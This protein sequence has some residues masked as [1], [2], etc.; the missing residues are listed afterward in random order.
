MPGNDDPP[1]PGPIDVAPAVRAF[2]RHYVQREYADAR[3]IFNLNTL[4]LWYNIPIETLALMLDDIV[5]ADPLTQDEALGFQVFLSSAKEQRFFEP[6]SLR[7]MND[8]SSPSALMMRFGYLLDLRLRGHVT[9][10]LSLFDVLRGELA[11]IQPFT[12]RRNSWPQFL[13]LQQGITAMLAGDFQ[14]ALNHF[15]ETLARS[16]TPG[17]EV[18]HRNAII[19]SALLEA[20]FG[21]PQAAQLLYDR[22]RKVKRTPS[23]SEASIDASADLVQVLLEPDPQL[24]GRKLAMLDLA[25]VGEMWPFYVF[26]DYIVHDRAGAHARISTRLENMNALPF[27]R[28]SGE[29][30]SGSVLPLAMASH[31]LY[32]GASQEARDLVQQAD[33]NHLLT[34][35]VVAMVELRAGSPQ[36]TIR[37]TKEVREETVE[38]RRAELWRISLCAQAYLVLGDRPAMINV[39]REIENLFQPLRPREVN[40]FTNELAEA[41]RQSFDW[42][43][44]GELDHGAYFERL[45]LREESLTDREQEVLELLALGKTRPQI[46]ESLY[47]SLN[48]LKTQL[49]SVYRK[50]GAV[51]RADA[52]QK[53]SHRGLL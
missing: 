42:W 45:P 15:T 11:I 53:A 14:R 24:A 52:L 10:A 9:E 51:S 7:T 31:K 3:E 5:T 8:T 35:L 32:A 20:A 47:I 28:E 1:R 34:K 49:R 6:R 13:S 16:V 12:D 39:M 29:G 43:P 18:L 48:T 46:A 26:A 50:L 36:T 44:T 22:A 17:L 30:F 38:L 33:P 41:G 2:E 37:L 40:F 25:E 27:A 4:I 23:W 21:N 19:R